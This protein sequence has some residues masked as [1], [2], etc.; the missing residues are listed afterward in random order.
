MAGSKDSGISDIL[1]RK[2]EKIAAQKEK[3]ALNDSMERPLLVERIPEGLYMCRYEGG[4]AIPEEF[5]GKHTNRIKLQTL[6]IRRWG[7]ADK[8]KFV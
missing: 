1:A 7:N 3:A 2:G 4:G 5:K 6:A 8:L